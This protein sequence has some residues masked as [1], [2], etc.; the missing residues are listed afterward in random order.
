MD[1]LP[2]FVQGIVRVYIS[3]PFDYVRTHLQVNPRSSWRDIPIGRNLYRGVSVPLVSVPID[4]SIQFGIYERC[5]RRGF[6]Q[7]VSSLLATMISSVYSVPMNYLQTH[8][9]VKNAP[10]RWASLSFRGYGADTSRAFLSSF[11]YLSTYGTLR[12]HIPNNP[13][14]YFLFGTIS[15]SVVWSV[16]YPLDTM[17]VLKQTTHSSASYLEISKVGFRSLY[18]GFP[19]VLARSIPSSGFGMLAY[20]TVRSLL[21]EGDA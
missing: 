21:K 6:S 20:E 3:Y 17:R 4:R 9:I 16:A 8:V 1:F 12:S 15:S 7:P 5:N 10:I 13:Y 19:I 18:S 14:T 11:L 2:G